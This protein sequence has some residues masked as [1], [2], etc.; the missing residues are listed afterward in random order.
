M[1][2]LA[3]TELKEIAH[4]EQELSRLQDFGI[5]QNVL[6]IVVPESKKQ[7]WLNI[8]E[9]AKAKSEELKNEDANFS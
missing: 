3:P 6:R 7:M 2:K 5:T 4:I 9:L 1:N 8:L